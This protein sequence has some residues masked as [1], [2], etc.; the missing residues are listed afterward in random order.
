MNKTGSTLTP[1]Q[2]INK[3]GSTL[4]PKGHLPD[5]VFYADSEY[6]LDIF[7]ALILAELL[8]K[9]QPAGLKWVYV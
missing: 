7:P 3:M 8:K 4:T 6:M 9:K 5:K 1:G 2:K